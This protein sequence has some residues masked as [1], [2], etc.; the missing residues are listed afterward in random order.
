MSLG[1]VRGIHRWSVNCPHKGSVTRKM[2]PF[3]DVI[4]K[5]PFSL[6]YAGQRI[7]EAVYPRQATAHLPEDVSRRNAATMEAL[8]SGNAYRN[9]EWNELVAG[10]RAEGLGLETGWGHARADTDT[11]FLYGQCLGV[12]IPDGQNASPMNGSF[13]EMSEAET[14]C[15]CRVKVN[16]NVQDLVE[17]IGQVAARGAFDEIVAGG[18]IGLLVCGGTAL[19]NSAWFSL[20]PVLLIPFLYY[21]RLSSPDQNAQHLNS[22][23]RWLN[24][25]IGSNLTIGENRAKECFCFRDGIQYLSSAKVR[26]ML[27]DPRFGENHQGPAQTR[28]NTDLVPALVCSAP[29]PCIRDY[30]LRSRYHGWPTQEA[31]IDIGT[32]AAVIVPIGNSDSSA[33]EQ[34]RAYSPSPQELGLSRDMPDRMNVPREIPAETNQELDWRYSFSPQELRLSRDMPEWVKSG[35]RAAKYT[36][37]AVYK[38]K[39]SSLH[40]NGEATNDGRKHVSSFHLKTVLLWSLE[41]EFT[42]QE[43]CSFRVMLVLLRNLDHHL[44][45]GRMSHYFNHNCNLLQNISRAELDFTRSCVGEILCYP[46]NSMINAPSDTS[47]IQISSV[48]MNAL[49]QQFSNTVAQLGLQ[50]QDTE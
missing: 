15:F 45:T 22:V 23:R 25:A 11:M 33:H 6:Q 30:L 7:L 4:M 35:Y 48:D 43:T 21:Y 37:K 5:F 17:R 8:L 13:L 44:E 9:P 28:Y 38:R 32:I 1:F 14:P 26:G 3:D 31:L 50:W 12:H 49:R 36:F 41:H 39:L 40:G 42:W 20:L 18:S 24:G 10:S 34:G 29:F 2:F 46:V 16:G 47:R 19:V 27:S